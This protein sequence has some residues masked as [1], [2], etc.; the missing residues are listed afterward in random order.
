MNKIC[1]ISI[2]SEAIRYC[3]SIGF[4]MADTT[5]QIDNPKDFA[6]A[7]ALPCKYKMAF[8]DHLSRFQSPANEQ[9]R[10]RYRELWKQ[11]L[12]RQTGLPPVHRDLHI[13]PTPPQYKPVGK[14]RAFISGFNFSS[15]SISIRSIPERRI[16]V[17]LFPVKFRLSPK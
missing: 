14:K 3:H 5:D 16:V 15:R 12:Y 13:D 1:S 8:V 7:A 2:Q 10:C 4:D 9:F 17:M 6:K 11:L